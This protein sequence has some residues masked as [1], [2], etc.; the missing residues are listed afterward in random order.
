MSLQPKF[1][2]K[3]KETYKFHRAKLL[4]NDR[5]NT[6]LTA[7]AL[8]RSIGSISEDLMI[9][10]ACREYEKEIEKFKYAYQA[11]EFIREKNEEKDKVEIE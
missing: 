11:I 7:K 4:S 5:W 10:R 9:A 8:R 2:E 1:L 3:A 6:T